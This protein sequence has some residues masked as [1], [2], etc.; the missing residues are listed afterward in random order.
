VFQAAG[1]GAVC[2]AF[3]A[4]EVNAIAG[5]VQKVL[6]LGFAVAAV[7]AQLGLPGIFAG[8]FLSNVVMWAYLY[9]VVRRKYFRPAL[10]LDRAAAWAML[11]ASLPLGV[12]GI[13]RKASWQVD[14]LLLTALAGAASAGLYNAAYRFVHAVSLL[15][16]NI[17]Q[18]LFP[19]YARLGKRSEEALFAAHG[20]TLKFLYV[21][22]LPVPVALTVLADRIVDLFF[23]PAFAG[24]AP[25]LQIVGWA[26]VL[27]FPN[28]LYAYLFTAL[29]RQE[30]YTVSAGA[31]LGMNLLADLLLIPRYGVLGACVGTLIAELTLFL[32]GTHLLRQLG[33]RTSLPTAVW[34]PALGAAAMTALL[35]VVRTSSIPW[36]VAGVIAG[37]LVYLAGL[38]LLHAFSDDETLLL[39]DVGHAAVAAIAMQPPGRRG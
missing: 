22:V 32:V 39:R 5:I 4:M 10:V 38:W 28:A 24:A 9:L 11:R 31:C 1:Y 21:L 36:L 35:L 8:L 3:E 13:L 7:S 2:R 27:V 34:K 29:G 16:K 23:G 18:A 14:T 12:G 30:L 26:L 37:G 20:K 19:A 33:L 6:F 25:A 15:P 17:A